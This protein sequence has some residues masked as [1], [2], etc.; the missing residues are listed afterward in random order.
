MS[1]TPWTGWLC[2]SVEKVHGVDRFQELGAEADRLAGQAQ[3]AA[4]IETRSAGE[5]RTSPTRLRPVASGRNADLTLLRGNG[6]RPSDGE[7]LR[8]YRRAAS[9]DGVA[10]DQQVG[11][12][13]PATA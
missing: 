4:S 8:N 6:E 9:E 7:V 13:R 5:G 3:P 12:E 1:I 11:E 2:S 10:T